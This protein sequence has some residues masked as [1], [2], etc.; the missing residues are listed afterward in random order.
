MLS[1]QK[2]RFALDR[3]VHYLNCAYMSPLAREVEEAGIRGIQGKRTPH[4]ITPTDFFE[5]PRRL[6]SKFARLINGSD[7]SR[8]SLLPSVSYGIAIAAHNLNT[9]PGQNV[10]V[11][12]EQF[13][14]NIYTWLRIAEDQQLII[15]TIHRPES[16]DRLAQEW[17]ER[18]LDAID[19]ET[20]LVAMPIV[21]WTDG[22]LFD[23]HAIAERC[24]SC[25]AA[26]ILDGTQSIG[27]LPFD[28]QSVQPDALIVAGY[29]WLMGPYS[30]GF[31]WWGDRF[32]N[33]RPL[34]E[35]WINRLGSENFAGLV[36]YESAYQPGAERFDIGE[37]SN[38]ILT[39]ML[40][41]ALDMV[42]EWT[43]EGIQEYTAALISPFEEQIRQAG[44][45]LAPPDMRGS[46]LFGIR[47]PAGKDVVALKESLAKRRISVS[48]RG[49]AIRVSPHVYND[50]SDMAAL[51]DALVGHE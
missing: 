39:P 14:S 46:H 49:S 8:V 6:K 34:E 25:D 11:L 20:A 50:V 22:T 30:C 32:L 17:N 2:S 29:K 38:F 5:G 4:G 42:L 13:P 27:A 44:Y 24:R 48:A 36:E 15:R 51:V 33:G 10:V 45:E 40:E 28:V 3:D 35:N 21:H 47:L 9:T 12:H 41:A 16:T 26:L 43:P 1:C 23:V 37:K 31:A 18:I 7:P 19:S